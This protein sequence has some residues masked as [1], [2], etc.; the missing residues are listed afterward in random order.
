[1]DAKETKERIVGAPTLFAVWLGLL[2]LTWLTVMDGYLRSAA[3][4]L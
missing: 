4:S 2:G 1:M 3:P